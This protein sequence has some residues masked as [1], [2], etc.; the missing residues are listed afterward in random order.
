MTIA[1]ITV[2]GQILKQTIWNQKTFNFSG[3]NIIENMPII[4]APPLPLLKII[5]LPII[6]DN[7]FA[8]HFSR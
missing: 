7:I 1:A 3:G 8:D 6:T 4:S 2:F 5:L